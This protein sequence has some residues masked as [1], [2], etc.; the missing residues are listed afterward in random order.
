MTAQDHR[1][2]T[3][4]ALAL[5]SNVGDRR[6]HLRFAVEE[7]GKRPEISVDRCSSIFISEA[8]VLDDTKAQDDYLNA[9]VIVETSLEP[10]ELLTACLEIEKERG[11]TRSESVRWKSRTL[12]IDLLVFGRLR[13]DSVQLS[14][15]HPRMADRR[16]VL[17]PLFEIAPDLKIPAPFEQTVQYLLDHCKDRAHVEWY[18]RMSQETRTE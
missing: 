12:D 7:L 3:R 8:H 15:P 16:F 18:S 9:V 13:L 2:K 6:S 14:I 10:T 4:A 1:E 5:G 11:R 17:E